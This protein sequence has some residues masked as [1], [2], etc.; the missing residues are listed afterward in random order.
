[1]RYFLKFF[2]SE[3]IVQN[4]QFTIAE[5]DYITEISK[6][7]ELKNSQTSTVL[8][9]TNEGATVPFIAR[10]RKEKTE[11]LDEEQIR[12]ILKNKTRIENLYDAKKTAIN[13]IVELDKMTDELFENI[14]KAQSLKEVEDI[15]KPYK[16]KKKTKA[17][18]AIENGFQII[19]DEIKKNREMPA[20]NPLLVP[21]LQDFSYEEIID[22][23]KEIIA[24]EIAANAD[25]RADLIETLGKYGEINSKYKTEK[26]LEKLN[27]KDKAQI[28]KFAIYND[29]TARIAYLKPYQILALN[30][31]EK[32]EILNIKIEKTEKTFEGISLHYARILGQQA[33]EKQEQ[34]PSPAMAGSG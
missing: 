22:G 28:P 23:A 11:N 4:E 1:M 30:R 6:E 13:G 9:L 29:F 32:L 15:Y 21:F 18:I 20:E 19:A 25:L 34:D 14:L 31:G 3:T 8:E 33:R 17:M 27:E 7:L 26:M 16:S 12:E 24:A 2:M 5:P 10:Y